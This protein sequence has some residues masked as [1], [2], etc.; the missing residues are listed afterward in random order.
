MT[1]LFR[2]LSY[3]PL[4]LLHSLGWILG[5]V[6]YLSSAGYRHRFVE[7]C[8]FAGVS[9]T[10][11]RRA[12]GE[13]GKMIA[14]LP[15]L[16]MGRPV[17]VH[18]TGPQHVEAALTNSKGILFLTPHMGCFE[19]TGQAYAARFGVLGHPVTALYRPPRKEWLREVVSASRTRPGL[20]S[21]PTTL[22]G[23]KQLFKALK[24]GHCV[25]LLPDQVPPDGMG[26]W[27][28]F[29][30]QPAY[31]MIL[32]AR[33]ALQ[34]GATVLLVWGERLPWGRGYVMHAEPLPYSLS[35]D[36]TEAVVQINQAMEH[37]VMQKPSQY[38]WGYARY[39]A[40]RSGEL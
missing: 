4:W 30:G 10:D 8:A 18:W 34:S 39:K 23:V 20:D 35:R 14:E 15:R 12:V 11:R 31:T 26:V 17:P 22:A 24:N 27:A 3:L 9:N 28:P 1:T 5:W 40:P 7:N 32:S 38:L 6:T 21:A 36:M 13:A 16:W 33:L 19:V 25:G 2:L 37:L 29:F